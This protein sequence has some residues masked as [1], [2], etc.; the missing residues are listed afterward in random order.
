[1]SAL[2]DW[3]SRS[4]LPARRKQRPTAR[5]FPGP[6][7]RLY[8]HAGR[9]LTYG[10]WARLLGVSAATVWRRIHEYGWPL[11]RALSAP[12]QKGG[13]RPKS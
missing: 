9:T 11:A 7:V 5:Y 4:P 10:E 2:A 13:R 1:M 3:L 8:S 6:N 12:R